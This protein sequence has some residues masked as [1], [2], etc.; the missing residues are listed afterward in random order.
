MFGWKWN[1]C[2]GGGAEEAR[3]EEGAEKEE[4]RQARYPRKVWLKCSEVPWPF[5]SLFYS[6]KV[7]SLFTVME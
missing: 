1:W 6:W 4:S 5:L 2:W 7:W 3:E